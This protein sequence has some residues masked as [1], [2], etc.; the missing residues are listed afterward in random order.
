MT[1]WNNLFERFFPKIAMKNG[2]FMSIV[3][4]IKTVYVMFDAWVNNK[5]NRDI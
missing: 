2:L 3:L 4:V 1:N 5:L